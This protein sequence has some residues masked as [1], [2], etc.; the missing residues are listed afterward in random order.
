LSGIELEKF[1]ERKKCL[2]I[3]KNSLFMKYDYKKGE[4]IEEDGTFVREL[5]EIGK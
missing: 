5:K 2:K 4:I 1:F 3:D